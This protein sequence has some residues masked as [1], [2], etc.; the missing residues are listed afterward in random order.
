MWSTRWERPNSWVPPRILRPKCA[1]HNELATWEL[2]YVNCLIF[3]LALLQ[4]KILKIQRAFESQVERLTWEWKTQLQEHNNNKKDTSILMNI[5]DFHA[6]FA[7]EQQPLMRPNTLTWTPRYT[8]TRPFPILIFICTNFII[9]KWHGYV[10]VCR[11]SCWL[12]VHWNFDC[13]W[14]R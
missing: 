11:Y 10:F 7:L 1:N 9:S 4:K 14:M 6:K 13:R 2:E 3:L 5:I 8:K 12:D